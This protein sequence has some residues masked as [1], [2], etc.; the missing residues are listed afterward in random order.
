MVAEQQIHVGAVAEKAV[1]FSRARRQEVGDRA[2]H[3]H[4]GHLVDDKEGLLVRHP[5]PFL[6][7]GIIAGAEAVGVQP[8]HARKIPLGHGVVEAR[9]K[10]SESSCLP[11][12]LR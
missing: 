9:P 2:H 11:K 8:L 12:P 6:G 3:A 4:A 10:M 1:G 7:V 5:V